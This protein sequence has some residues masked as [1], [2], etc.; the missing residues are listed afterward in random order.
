MAPCHL[1][2]DQVNCILWLKDTGEPNTCMVWFFF[3]FPFSDTTEKSDSRMDVCAITGEFYC[4]EGREWGTH[5]SNF[6]KV[7]NC[8]T[9]SIFL[10]LLH[11][12]MGFK[13]RVWKQKCSL[14]LTVEQ[15]TQSVE[16]TWDWE[17]KFEFLW[18]S[19]T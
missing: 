12:N 6:N 1:L 8:F 4:R 16:Y 17:A 9:L 19:K 3:A 14:M 2:V 7:C 18:S 11:I 5:V 10:S 15:F 13:L